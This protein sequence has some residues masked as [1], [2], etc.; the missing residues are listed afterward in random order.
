MFLA[1]VAKGKL[2][3]FLNINLIWVNVTQVIY[4]WLRQEMGNF[5]HCKF[6]NL[7]TQIIMNITKTTYKNCLPI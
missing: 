6:V 5:K 4:F 7:N 3:N 1:V 2:Y